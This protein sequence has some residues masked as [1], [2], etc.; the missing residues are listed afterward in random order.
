MELVALLW[1]AAWN[2]CRPST[3]ERARFQWTI[4][5]RP[6]SNVEANIFLWPA[7]SAD[8]RTDAAKLEPLERPWLS[9]C[10]ADQAL[11]D[12]TEHDFLE[13]DLIADLALG[14]SERQ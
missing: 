2:A 11:V 4:P 6:S 8:R 3:I 7:P 5:E 9:S 10:A 14:I 13:D 1:A 12:L